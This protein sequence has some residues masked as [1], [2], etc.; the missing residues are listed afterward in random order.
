MTREEF[1]RE[2][3]DLR[4][5]G[6]KPEVGQPV[7]SMGVN[8]S[9]IRLDPPDRLKVAWCEY[10]PITAVALNKLDE[11]HG[12]TNFGDAARALGLEMTLADDIVNAADYWTTE[13]YRYRR[14]DMNEIPITAETLEAMRC[15]IEGY[16]PRAK[17]AYDLL[18]SVKKAEYEAE[19]V[20]TH[21]STCEVGTFDYWTVFTDELKQGYVQ[22]CGGYSDYD[23]G[24]CEVEFEILYEDFTHGFEL[25]R[26]RMLARMEVAKALKV[27]NAEKRRQ[28]RLDRL[29]AEKDRIEAKIRRMEEE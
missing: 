22:L 1:M 7:M 18:M 5:A 16:N 6:W 20:D 25:W 9:L 3:G 15:A 2:L 17:A 26:K 19:Y 12:S 21:Y 10:C 29:Q 14:S 28:D 27:E 13:G 4:A 24:F 23:L 11:D 8:C